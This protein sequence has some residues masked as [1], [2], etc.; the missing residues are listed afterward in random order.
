MLDIK[1][2]KSNMNQ[3]LYTADGKTG[4]PL[5]IQTIIKFFAICMI[6]LG[7]IFIGDAAYSLFSFNTSSTRTY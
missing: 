7:V 5:P 3:I 6:V 4:G 2:W 1:E